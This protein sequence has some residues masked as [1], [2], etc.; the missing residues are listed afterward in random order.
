MK[1][2]RQDNFN[3]EMVSEVF[4]AQQLSVWYADLIVELLN[5]KESVNSPDYYKVVEDDYEL[6][7]WE[8]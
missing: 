5:S 1:I 4:V 6:Y 2:I 3:R 8:P 7:E